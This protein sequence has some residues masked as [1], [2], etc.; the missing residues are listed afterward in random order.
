MIAQ[1]DPVKS[2]VIS[3][4]QRLSQILPIANFTLI[5]ITRNKTSWTQEHRQILT[6]AQKV[7]NTAVSAV[8]TQQM[9]N[10]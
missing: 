10:Y 5:Y 2:Q 1:Q 9:L 7:T 4:I 3:L 6:K 8:N